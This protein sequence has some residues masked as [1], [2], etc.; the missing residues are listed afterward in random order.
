MAV[1]GEAKAMMQPFWRLTRCPACDAP[2]GWLSVSYCKGGDYC[3]DEVAG[4]HLHKSCG[5]C[6]YQ[7]LEQPA[8]IEE[9]EIE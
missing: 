6:K 5:M 7:W 9:G 8:N 1:E 3:P 2:W 4:V